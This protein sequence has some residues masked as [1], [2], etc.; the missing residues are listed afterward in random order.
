MLVIDFGPKLIEVTLVKH[1]I[2][3]PFNPIVYLPQKSIFKTFSNFQAQQ[4]TK[5]RV[6]AVETTRSIGGMQKYGTECR[7]K[8][9]IDEH[10]PD[11]TAMYF[12]DQKFTCLESLSITTYSKTTT[13]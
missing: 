5:F 8:A 10:L 4:C 11:L 9:R 6:L 3:I 12:R 13:F 7:I 2:N 1:K